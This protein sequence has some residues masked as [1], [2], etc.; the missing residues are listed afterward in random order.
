MRRFTLKAVLFAVV[1]VALGSAMRRGDTLDDVAVVGPK[2]RHLAE[3]L[4]QYDTL[5]VGSSYVYREVAP[6]V[7]DETLARHGVAARSFN[8]GVPGMDPPETYALVERVLD[9]APRSLETVVIELDYYR[10][11]V[12]PRDLHTRRFDYW[13]DGRVTVEVLRAIAE[14]GAP[15]GKK[16]K[17]VAS[18]LEAYAR[19]SLAV[20]RGPAMLGAYRAPADALGPRVDGFVSLDSE[21]SGGFALRR[22]M[23]EAIEGDR[24]DEKVAAL[25]EVAGAE[26]RSD[27][28]GAVDREALVRVV[29]RVRRHGARP[30]L[31]VPPCLAPRDDLIRMATDELG[32]EVLV[33]NDP[34]AYPSLYGVDLRF[35]VGHLNERGAL[36]FTRMLAERIAPVLAK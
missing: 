13:H 6:A 10:E 35:D 1:L 21:G 4:D 17:D 9:L 18:H 28:V 33:F 14:S 11:Q 2:L 12:R 3:H 7:Y 8:L 15:R 19:R 5:F 29:D 22:G 30:V 34:D 20:G 16:G 27:G 25:R 36:E 31:L 26:A 23:F 32:L 24:L